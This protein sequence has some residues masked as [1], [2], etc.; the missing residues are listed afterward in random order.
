MDT[1]QGRPE[2]LSG[3]ALTSVGS[4]RRRARHRSPPR[5]VTDQLWLEPFSQPTSSHFGVMEAKRPGP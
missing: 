4:V 5:P 3:P 1:R 2:E